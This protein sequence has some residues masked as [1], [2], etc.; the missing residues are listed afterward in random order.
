M[1]LFLRISNVK[2]FSTYNNV[3]VLID[4]ALKQLTCEKIHQKT[5]TK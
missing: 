4:F 3:N 1:A 5:I 2:S